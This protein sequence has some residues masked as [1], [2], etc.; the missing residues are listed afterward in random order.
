MPYR[1]GRALTE[2]TTK[3]GKVRRI[4]LYARWQALR[5]RVKG[6]QLS[7]NGRSYWKGLPI[8]FRDWAHF[9]EWSLANGYSKEKCS[10]DRL[11]SKKGYSPDNCEWVTVAENGL[12][13]AQT[14][15]RK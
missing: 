12:R 11:D 7:K 1:R 9:R 5:A 13:G 3:D 10:L 8:N 6:S 15:W 2:W 14:R 4:R